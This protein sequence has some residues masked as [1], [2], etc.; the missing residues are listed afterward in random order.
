MASGIFLVCMPHVGSAES[1]SLDHQGRPSNSDFKTNMM[2][3]SRT[4]LSP[5]HS[6]P[7]CEREVTQGDFWFTAAF[8]KFMSQKFKSSLPCESECPQHA[9]LCTNADPEARWGWVTRP[10]PR[11]GH[12]GVGCGVGLCQTWPSLGRKTP[13]PEGRAALPCERPEALSPGKDVQTTV[14]TTLGGFTDPPVPPT[15][16][17]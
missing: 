16:Q 13:N 12:A 17:A 6:G 11:C 5:S 3:Y 1:K 8:K 4:T 10:G 9:Q 15:S 7:S 14:N 2:L